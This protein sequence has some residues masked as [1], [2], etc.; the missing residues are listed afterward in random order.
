MTQIAEHDTEQE[1]ERDDG[2]Q[3][4]VSFLIRCN[5][6]SV[7]QVLEAASELVGAIECRWSF[8]RF[9]DVQE[10]WDR[11]ANSVRSIGQG[12]LNLWKILYWHPALADHALLRD[13]HVEQIHRV[14]NRFHLLDH[15][16]PTRKF[17]GDIV[18]NALTMI[19]RLV[20]NHV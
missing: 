9:D 8:N 16:R 18:Q 2:V 6:V 4:W 17:L 12:L 19:L 10:R 3:C 15:D 1:R 14:V 5:S 20:Q 7:N 13:V 11:G